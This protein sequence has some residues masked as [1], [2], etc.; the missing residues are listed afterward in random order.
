MALW[1]LHDSY[2]Y[3]SLI[4]R[5]TQHHLVGCCLHRKSSPKQEAQSALKFFTFC[6]ANL[7]KTR[8]ILK[9]SNKQ[10]CNFINLGGL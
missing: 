5:D 9:R 10:L 3:Y 7:A 8:A 6:M 1:F 2:T 4:L